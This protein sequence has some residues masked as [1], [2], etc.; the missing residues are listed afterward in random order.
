MLLSKEIFNLLKKNEKLNFYFLVFLMIINSCFEILGITSIIPIISITVKNDLSFFEGTFLFDY[1]N[2]F[3]KKDNFIFL[4][5]IFVGSIFLIKNIYISYYN[6]YLSKFQCNVVERLSNDIYLHYLNLDYKNY[7]KLKT[8]KIIYDTT[9]AVEVFR[10]NLLNLSSFLLETIVL[11]IIISFLIYLNPLS[12]LVTILILTLLSLTFFYFFGKQNIFW[13]SEVKKSSKNRINILNTSF[14]SIKDV[15]IYSGENFFYKKFKLQNFVLNKFQKF[16]LFF[17]GLPKPFFEAII[18][19]IFLSS[20]YYFLKI[21]NIDYEIIILNLAI[22]AV[23]MFRIYPSIYRIAACVQK[24]T[25]G[26]AVLEDLNEIFIIK[27]KE[28]IS[29]NKIEQLEIKNFNQINIKNVNFKYEDNL[30]L[31]LKN[32]NLKLIKGDFIG[33]R[34]ETGVGKS[35]LVD[36]ICGLL[37]PNSGLFQ[38]DDKYLSDTLPRKWHYKI[39]YVPQNISLIDDTLVRNIALAINDNEINYE[40]IN[41]IIKLSQLEKFINSHQRNSILGER[42]VQVSGGEKQRIGIARALYHDRPIY[43]FDEATNALD[44]FT[45]NEILK[46]LKNHLKNKIVIIISHKP[47]T[48][49][50]CD[51]IYSLKNKELKLTQ[52]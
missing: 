15:K 13:G 44:E 5:F 6:Y 8:S 29:S 27:N 35:T 45:E 20:L 11:L 10:G 25:F 23:S 30:D 9:E 41:E 4:S 42:G 52:I 50:F 26:K 40:K 19:I 33:I 16:H 37:K 28:K 21:K 32:L 34:G 2:D 1:L 51:R 24:G 22:F 47:S 38:I 43:I 18:V 12:T 7:L 48:L 46:S 49:S 3:S 39:G 17:S 14:F 31:T 36:L